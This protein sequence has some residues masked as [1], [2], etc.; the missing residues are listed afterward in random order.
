MTDHS[1]RRAV[2]VDGY[3]CKPCGEAWPCAA[4]YSVTE[5][6]TRDKREVA[7]IYD[8]IDEGDEE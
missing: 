2:G 3:V 8:F 1:P 4:Y 7:A 5:P 6:P